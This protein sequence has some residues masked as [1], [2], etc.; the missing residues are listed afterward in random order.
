MKRTLLFTLACIV[1]CTVVAPVTGG[2]V[3]SQLNSPADLDLSGNI[4]Y[5][6]NFGTGEVQFAGTTFMSPASYPDLSYI[7]S[8]EGSVLQWGAIYPNTGNSNLDK[9]L[10]GIAIKTSTSSSPDGSIYVNASGLTVGKLYQLQTIVYE[11]LPLSRVVDFIVEGT[12]IASNIETLSQQGGVV[13]QGGF[14]VTH[15]FTATDTVLNFAITPVNTA[16]GA[17]TGLSAFVVSEIP[18][19]T[20][21]LLLGLGGLLSRRRS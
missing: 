7:R 18:E 13:G 14:R 19:P 20:A 1:F 6:V 12:T 2:L 21:I 17:T 9:L 8:D 15:S 4:I 11:P 10:G 16:L 5:A 3:I